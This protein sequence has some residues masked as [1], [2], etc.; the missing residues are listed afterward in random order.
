MSILALRHTDGTITTLKTN[1]NGQKKKHTC[2]LNNY[3]E[4]VTSVDVTKKL[5]MNFCGRFKFATDQKKKHKKHTHT[6]NHTGTQWYN[7]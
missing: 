3:D 1:A 6:I 4:R 2:D 7:I 5:T